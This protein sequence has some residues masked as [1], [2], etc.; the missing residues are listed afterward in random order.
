M[1]KNRDKVFF[2]E[3]HRFLTESERNGFKDRKGYYFMQNAS[4]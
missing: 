4:F 2:C 1:M 3:I